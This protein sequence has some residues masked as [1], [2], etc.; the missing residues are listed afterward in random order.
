MAQALTR[1]FNLQEHMPME[2]KFFYFLVLIQAVFMV[3]G[4][5]QIL[6]KQSFEKGTDSVFNAKRIQF[7]QNSGLHQ[8]RSD[9]PE[10]AQAS[11]KA[12]DCFVLGIIPLGEMTDTEFWADMGDPAGSKPVAAAE[13]PPAQTADVVQLHPK[14]DASEASPAAEVDTND[15]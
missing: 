12:L 7:M 9:L 3:D 13:T 4:E 15:T 10:K 2:P 5:I 6:H 11:F 8:I 14:K 1:S